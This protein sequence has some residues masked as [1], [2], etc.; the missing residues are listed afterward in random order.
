[1]RGSEPVVSG[2]LRSVQPPQNQAELGIVH[3]PCILPDENPDV[4]KKNQLQNEK[5]V[6]THTGVEQNPS[7]IKADDFSVHNLPKTPGLKENWN[8]HY[9]LK[10]CCP[11]GHVNHRNPRWKQL[12]RPFI[13]S[14]RQ[15]W[16]LPYSFLP[17]VHT[18]FIILWMKPY[19]IRSHILW[20]RQRLKV[21]KK[22]YIHYASLNTIFWKFSLKVEHYEESLGKHIVV[23]FS[24]YN[25]PQNPLN[26]KDQLTVSGCTFQ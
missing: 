16:G 1:M 26:I 24:N 7:K 6:K 8:C 22:N 14:S 25:L 23:E 17:K 21:L 19:V 3:Q 13:S 4:D 10:V 12:H 18:E 9:N 20:T 2:L 15:A 5:N 11:L